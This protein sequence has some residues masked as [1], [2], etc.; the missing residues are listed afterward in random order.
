MLTTSS[1][2]P[3]LY[4]L[5]GD[6]I[7]RSVGS[8]WLLVEVVSITQ[9]PDEAEP[10][11]RIDF[12]DW[13]SAT[14]PQL[15]AL[16]AQRMFD[17]HS[18]QQ[19]TKWADQLRGKAL[20]VDLSQAQFNARRADLRLLLLN[21]FNGMTVG[22]LTAVLEYIDAGSNP[23]A[24]R[25]LIREACSWLAEEMPAAKI[26]IEAMFSI[27]LINLAADKREAA[28]AAEAGQVDEAPKVAEP[29]A[30]QPGE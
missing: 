26:G 29:V 6:A 4:T 23:A 7:I 2:T 9:A 21:V 8:D 12:S 30:D 18:L 13:Y 25:G 14:N 15:A 17:Y 1:H 19:I 27:A 3:R 28:Q 5:N 11:K 16:D 10:T 22:D 24:E 20:G